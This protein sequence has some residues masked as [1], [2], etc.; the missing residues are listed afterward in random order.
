MLAFQ[1]F[2]KYVY[3]K[4]MG[5]EISRI[6]QIDQLSSD[7]IVNITKEDLISG[8]FRPKWK[9]ASREDFEWVHAECW[10]IVANPLFLFSSAPNSEFV[11]G[12]GIFEISAFGWSHI[13]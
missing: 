1:V 6:E 10:I 4:V 2:Q 5:N 13:F 8:I 9:P 3:F 12:V 11:V 7:E